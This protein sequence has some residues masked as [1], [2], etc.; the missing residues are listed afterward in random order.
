MVPWWTGV[1]DPQVQEDMETCAALYGNVSWP[2][3]VASDQTDRWRPSDL[4]GRIST[5]CRV[6]TQG[7]RGGPGGGISGCSRVCNDVIIVIIVMLF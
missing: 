6:Q 7:S 2:F 3:L 5:G 1:D 4:S